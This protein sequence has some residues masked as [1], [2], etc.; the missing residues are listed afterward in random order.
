MTLE[1]GLQIWVAL[2]RSGLEEKRK[3]HLPGY[4]V[5][6]V[7]LLKEGLYPH[8]AYSL[9]RELRAAPPS[10]EA[11][12]EVLFNALKPFSEMLRDVLGMF[13]AAGARRSNENLRIAFDF[14]KASK[15]LAL[16][17]MEFR[18]MEAFFRRVVRPIVVRRWNNNTL[19][20]L[21]RD[22]QNVLE[23]LGVP[24]AQQRFD[25]PSRVRDPRVREWIEKNGKPTWLP[26]P[27]FPTSGDAELDKPLGMAEGL[28]HYMI[29]EVRKLGTTYEEFAKQ[30][31]ELPWE[32][33]EEDE[34]EGAAHDAEG[35]RPRRAFI[36]AA[37][38]FWPNSFAEHV[39][40]GVEAVND[41]T[42][43]EKSESAG[44]LAAAVK[45]GFD[46]APRYERN[47][48]SLEQDF[49]DLVNLPIWKK[50]HELYAVWVASRIADALRDLSF[51]WH[52]DGDT[53]RFPFSGA[54]LATL[55]GGDGSTHIFWTE[56]RTA[57]DGG[58]LF[59]R[60][61][62]QP[63][64]RIMTVPTHRNDATSLVVECKQYRNWSRKNFGAA[65]DDYAKGCPK[66]PVVLV[67]Y[68]PTDPSILGLVDASRR[69]RT[70]LVGDFKPGED[71][72]LDRFRELVRSAYTT[73]LTPRI[74]GTIKC[75]LLGIS[76]HEP[77]CIF[78]LA[79]PMTEQTGGNP[80][81]ILR[82]AVTRPGYPLT[83]RAILDI[84]SPGWTHRVMNSEWLASH[85]LFDK[86]VPRNGWALNAPVPGSF[87]RDYL[88]QTDDLIQ[89][90]VDPKNP[91]AKSYERA[92]KQFA[93][94]RG[95][96]VARMLDDKSSVAEIMAHLEITDLCRPT[97]VELLSDVFLAVTNHKASWFIK[98]YF[99]T[100]TPSGD[101]GFL[102][103][104]LG[105]DGG[106]VIASVH[107]TE[108]HPQ[109]G[110]IFSCRS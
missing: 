69:D 110:A 68:G 104:G 53:L 83:M 19:F 82:V 59:R 87:G 80:V 55:L 97:A 60:K 107:P 85:P 96:V 52:P 67:N 30:L 74:I 91:S 44:R 105:A 43:E 40:L 31:A 81:L 24:D 34:A 41:H 100:S 99:W 7:R 9:E 27:G 35:E 76:V 108:R 75:R 58:G 94:Q 39:C 13:E 54:E 78:P 50:R 37:H 63:D 22:V 109:L 29:A 106:I 72:A 77:S 71:T 10:A 14:D 103:I 16:T 64:Y 88:E 3:N 1:N 47:R 17:L 21:S 15:A 102:A 79:M 98:R 101:G 8:A 32:E 56:K 62:I 89:L 93:E 4:D 95:E 86:E 36:S 5:E 2:V 45:I 48:I 26:F 20:S 65:L 28:I 42:N 51:E 12:L 57:L 84:A 70:F 38:D 25:A 92:Y 61:H 49:R 90:A 66:A 33:R 73:L 23:S 11:F 18:E 6:L 46:R